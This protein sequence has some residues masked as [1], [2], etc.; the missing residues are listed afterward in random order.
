MTSLTEHFSFLR[1]DNLPPS[2]G[3][4]QSDCLSEALLD[5][6]TPHALLVLVF[7]IAISGGPTG[8]RQTVNV[9][10]FSKNV[11]S[12]SRMVQI[13]QRSAFKKIF[14][15][16]LTKNTRQI[17]QSRRKTSSIALFWHCYFFANRYT[18][19]LRIA[20]SLKILNV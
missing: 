7:G 19:N 15:K 16:A 1:D 18:T 13:A 3:R 6:R 8:G 10:P 12:K 2:T 4:V 11:F 20:V 9:Y 14:F 5:V 17:L